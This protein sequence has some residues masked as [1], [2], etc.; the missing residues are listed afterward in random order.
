[1]FNGRKLGRWD[2]TI[3]ELWIGLILSVYV[4]TEANISKTL[5]L[6]LLFCRILI[7]EKASCL[8]AVAGHG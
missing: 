1:M 2:K 4:H 8:M 7:L 6:K 3:S 5:H